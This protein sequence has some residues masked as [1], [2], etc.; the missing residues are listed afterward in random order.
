MDTIDAKYIWQRR[1]HSGIRYQKGAVPFP[2]SVKIGLDFNVAFPRAEKLDPGILTNGIMLDICDFAKA[3]TKAEKYFMY[4]IMDFNFDLGLDSE[5]Q[6]YD[7]ATRVHNKVKIMKE[8][9]KT[10]PQRKKEVFL[11]PDP[12]I[13]SSAPEVS[14][15]CYAFCQVSEKTGLVDGSRNGHINL[16]SAERQKNDCNGAL[17]DELIVCKPNGVKTNLKDKLYPFC[18]EIGLTLDIRPRDTPKQKL[19]L[20]LLSNGVMLEVLDFAKVL[21]GT[22]CQIVFDVLEHNFS[23][24]LNKVIT[25]PLITKLM[26]RRN[27]GIT[28]DVRAAFRAEPFVL[29]PKTTGSRVRK[30][31]AAKPKHQVWETLTEDS[32]RKRKPTRRDCFVFDTIGTA[33]DSDNTFWQDGDLSYMCPVDAEREMFSE[34]ETGLENMKMEECLSGTATGR[35]S[36]ALMDIRQEEELSKSTA[37]PLTARGVWSPTIPHSTAQET[38]LDLFS[39]NTT[40]NIVETPKLR[41]WRRR[42]GRTKQILSM[43]IRAKFRFAHCRKVGLDFNV[44]SGKKQNIDLGLLTNGI[45]IEVSKFAN[46]MTR[47]RGKF[48][49]DILKNNFSLDLQDVSHERNF[50]FYILTKVK[51]LQCQPFRNNIQFLNSA[52]HLPEVYNMVDVT[53]DFAPQD[54]VIEQQTNWD[55]ASDIIQ[56]PDMEAYPFCKKMGLNLWVTDERPVSEKLDLSVLTNGA[57]F[58]M[59][60]FVQELCG[61]HLQVIYDVLQHNFDLDLQDEKA[62]VAQ[63]IRKWFL[64]HKFMMKKPKAKQSWLNTTFPLKGSQR[65]PFMAQF[66]RRGTNGNRVKELLD[67]QQLYHDSKKEAWT[68]DVQQVQMD[69]YSSYPF[70]TEIGLDLDVSL[71]SET[72]TK[73]NLQALT[74]G[75]VFEIHQFITQ[76]SEVLYLQA[77]Y[78]ILEYNFDLNVQSDRK[79]EFAWCVA[80]Q[81]TAMVS[82]SR[83]YLSQKGEYFKKVFELP[84][85]CSGSALTVCKEEPE[86][87]HTD[88]DTYDSDDILFVQELTPVDIIVKLE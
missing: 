17:N 42:A 81:V 28:A 27:I 73:L 8:N 22:H 47:T 64:V 29:Q 40:G 30:R 82:K 75:A 59:F 33:P 76:K 7:F 56:N 84:F 34:P 41:L 49:L 79:W 5:M 25:R 36:A 12:K 13:L 87:D 66:R 71:K 52:F 4:E 48:I 50:L 45:L 2:D 86:N 14:G 54:D 55:P 37:L 39:V 51:G 38:T 85:E 21:C 72:K 18:E 60:N 53:S 6:C 3:V 10:K 57:V 43:H 62:A 35:K 80:W 1:I 9:I 16:T 46:A 88:L 11:L 65:A 68:G 69:K 31:Q 74:R 63:R 32:K 58:E 19:D 23:V 15:L 44:G 26:E 83:R 67:E 20:N 78:E 70:C 77:L 61:T 24:S